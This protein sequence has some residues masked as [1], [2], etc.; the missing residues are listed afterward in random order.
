MRRRRIRNLEALISPT[1]VEQFH[2]VNGQAATRAPGRPV[3]QLLLAESRDLLSASHDGLFGFLDLILVND[4]GHTGR[5]DQS[6]RLIDQVAR[7][8][9]ELLRVADRTWFDHPTRSSPTGG[10]ANGLSVTSAW[11]QILAGNV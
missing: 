8:R 4:T 7:I 10:S 5:R 3:R 11:N 6:S 9:A 2:G 1:A